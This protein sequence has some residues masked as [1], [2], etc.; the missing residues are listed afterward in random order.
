M[1]LASREKYRSQRKSLKNFY[2]NQFF[3]LH[4]QT[5]HSQYKIQ[6]LLNFLFH[7][8]IH[9]KRFDILSQKIMMPGLYLLCVKI[10]FICFYIL[11][12]FVFLSSGKFLCCS[13]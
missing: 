3:S 10:F 5:Q 13:R 6:K 11:L 2:S 12:S 8:L 7:G 9:K 1:L 4:G